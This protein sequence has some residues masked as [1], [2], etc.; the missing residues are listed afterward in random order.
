MATNRARYYPNLS[1]DVS[2]TVRIEMKQV[3]DILY[4]LRDKVM[5]D[6]EQITLTKDILINPPTYEGKP[7]LLVVVEDATG[8]W[9]P[10]FHT[11][12]KGMA[13]FTWVT[14]ANTYSTLMFYPVKDDVVLLLSGVSGMAL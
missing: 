8:G 1:K 3:R 9:I 6:V 13:A 5:W 4:D 2:P 10:T 11:K 12:F 7:L 14:T